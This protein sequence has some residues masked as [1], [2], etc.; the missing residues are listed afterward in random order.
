MK[1]SLTL[2]GLFLSIV[3]NASQAA[4]VSRPAPT[5]R[6]DPALQAALQA[7]HSCEKMGFAVVVTVV[8]RQIEPVVTLVSE[9][10]FAHAIETSERKA[11][12]AASRRINTAEISAA[13]AHESSIGQV[14]HAIGLTTLSGGL[15]LMQGAE[16]IGGIGVAGAPG[17]NAQ[18]QD[19]D[20]LCAEAGLK[21]I[22]LAS[23]VKKSTSG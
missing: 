13:N 10:A 22:G 20:S 12:T 23:Q 18:G 8:G 1:H 11:R 5:I 19:Y 7:K 21:A 15:P 3:G 16:V 9:G 17:Q 14:F 4:E 6:F 2:L